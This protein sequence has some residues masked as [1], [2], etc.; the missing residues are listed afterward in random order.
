MCTGE[1]FVGYEVHELKNVRAKCLAGCTLAVRV[2]RVG[3]PLRIRV[4]IY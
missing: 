1:I 2:L 3:S 4:V